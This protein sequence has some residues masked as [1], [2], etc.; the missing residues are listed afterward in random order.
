MN[1]QEEEFLKTLKWYKCASANP[2]GYV[3]PTFETNIL[4]SAILSYFGS[5]FIENLNYLNTNIT[6][7]IFN[8]TDEIKQLRR[9]L[10]SGPTN[11]YSIY[12][13]IT[14]ELDT[15]F[16]KYIVDYCIKYWKHFKKQAYCADEYPDTAE[17]F[18]KRIL[19]AINT[20]KYEL[21]RHSSTISEIIRSTIKRKDYQLAFKEISDYII[22]PKFRNTWRPTF[23]QQCVLNDLPVYEIP[24]ED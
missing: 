4:I 24:F 14:N 5:T 21:Y 10:Y 7:T 13:A 22:G 12:T 20:I 9:K 8:N 11:H 1:N 2:S 23:R 3:N 6:P 18:K 19:I 16:A 15:N 17:D